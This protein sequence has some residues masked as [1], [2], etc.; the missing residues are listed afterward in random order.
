MTRGAVYV[1]ENKFGGDGKLYAISKRSG[2]VLWYK[3][4]SKDKVAFRG[5]FAALKG[6]SLF[7]TATVEESYFER[8]K[9]ARIDTRSK[10]ILMYYERPTS[11][12]SYDI[13]ALCICN[14]IL[15][16]VYADRDDVFASKGV[17]VAYKIN[18]TKA[19]WQAAYSNS[20][21]TG[22]LACN[23]GKNIVY[24]PT[25]PYLYA[26]NA[27]TGKLIWKY[28]GYGAIYT[29]SVANGVIYFLSDTNMYAIDEQTKKRLRT[30]SL[31]YEA[32]PSTQVAVCDG[33]IYFSGDGG[34]CDLYA[35]GLPASDPP[36]VSTIP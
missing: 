31:G 8:G 15:L 32:E 10:K 4:K 33:M 22:K 26:Y 7:A 11:V 25:D 12:E 18:S 34:T 17:L 27:L 35:L 6:S 9:V 2:Q 19:V 3:S 16:V 21:V 13:A 29:P 24:V 30:F 23:P 36:T 1:V 14:D 20:A 5:H 28:T